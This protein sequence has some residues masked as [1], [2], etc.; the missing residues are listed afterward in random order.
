MQPAKSEMTKATT[1]SLP[2]GS[3]GKIMLTYILRVLNLADDSPVVQALTLEGRTD[4][5]SFLEMS[6]QDVDDLVYMQDGKPIIV[7]KFG[8]GRIKGFFGYILYRIHTKNPIGTDWTSVTVDELAAYRASV[9]FRCHLNKNT[10]TRS[11]IIP[12]YEH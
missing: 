1:S 2:T 8:R 11:P 10:T 4:I 3:H 9:H 12:S 7:P 6:D 5:T